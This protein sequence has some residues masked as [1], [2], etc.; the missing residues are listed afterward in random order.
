MLNSRVLDRI[1]GVGQ[2]DGDVGIENGFQ[3]AVESIS[4]VSGESDQWIV[5]VINQGRQQTTWKTKHNHM[6]KPLS[7]N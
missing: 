3:D 1:N 7:K 6:N 4:S 5:Q 2:Y